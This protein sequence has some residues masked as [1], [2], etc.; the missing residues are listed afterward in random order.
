MAP[1]GC[2]FVIEHAPA[3]VSCKLCG[4]EGAL[5]VPLI[6]CSSCGNLE[7]AL[8]SGGKFIIVAPSDMKRLADDSVARPVS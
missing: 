1:E 4:Q 5:F 8:L 2:D 7:V 6:A 3:T